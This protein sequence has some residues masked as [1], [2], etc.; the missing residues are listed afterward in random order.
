[1]EKLD[2]LSDPKARKILVECKKEARSLEE[3]SRRQKIPLPI[4]HQIASVL[5]EFDLIREETVVQR[6]EKNIS[7]YRTVTENAFVTLGER[8]PM[9]K[10]VFS[11]N[12]ARLSI[13]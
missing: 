3:L 6:E 11:N 1:M 12:M 4:C 5:V 2:V 8:E 7:L 13:A 10:L 9:I